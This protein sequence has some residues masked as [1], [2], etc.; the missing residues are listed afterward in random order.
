MMKKCIT[1]ITL[2][3][4]IIFITPVA[5]V[6]AAK[7]WTNFSHVNLDKEWILNFNRSID[8]ASIDNNVFITQ[9][10]TKIAVNTNVSQN[11]L[12]I[13]PTSK[14]ALNTNYTLVVTEQILD[15]YGK[16]MNQTINIP[17]TTVDSAQE[18]AY[19]S[20]LSEYDMIWDMVSNDYENFYLVGQANDSEVG[21]Y[22]T[23][24]G[25][26]AFGIV[27][28]ASRSTVQKKYGEPIKQITKDNKN[29]V[30]SY[31]DK[32]GNITSGTY[33]IND[34]YVTF[35]YDIYKND[36]VRSIAWVSAETENTKPGFFRTNISSAF[37]DATEEMMVHLINQ[38]RVAEGL[39]ALT[40][41][42]AYNPIARK[43]S[44]DMIANE[45]FG[46]VDP[47][48]DNARNRLNDGGLTFSYY[49]ENL[50]Y[51]QYSPIYAHEALMNSEGHRR[52]ILHADFTH[53]LVGV[54][55]NTKGVPYFTVNFYKK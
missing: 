12:K 48:G 25:K 30:Q 47:N 2:I 18:D 6:T 39:H 21:G 24:A 9:G 1:I 44:A 40:Y 54:D 3:M 19:K 29:Y 13:K 33:K 8:P 51:G 35:F 53:V 50:A 38:T 36:I 23:R 27:I 20:F 4:S 49:G 17:F 10:S 16:A 45:Y 31:K 52:N 7:T 15:K 55:F 43:H 41:T 22:E 5:Q 14:L 26:S 32:S 28:G 37:R 11:K 34:N 46:H 42:P